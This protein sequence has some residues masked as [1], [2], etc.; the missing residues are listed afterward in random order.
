MIKNFEN[1]NGVTVR[2]LKAWLA[3]VPDERPN[4][5]PTQVWLETGWCVSNPRREL[6]PLNGR[7]E[8]D[9]RNSCDVIFGYGAR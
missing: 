9:G 1:S 3:D 7:T 4:G 8:Q 2:D 5:E 6:W